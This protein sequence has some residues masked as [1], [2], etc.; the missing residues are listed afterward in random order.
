MIWTKDFWKGTA[1]RAIKT[2]FQTLVATVAVVAAGDLAGIGDV[3]WMLVA[4]VSGL[5]TILSV[6]TS[7]GNAEATAA[8]AAA[9]S[10]RLESDSEIVTEIEV[11][12]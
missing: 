1:E 6:A 8:K 10:A 2:F 4:S 5:A 3:D 7:I 11:D 9:T 12:A